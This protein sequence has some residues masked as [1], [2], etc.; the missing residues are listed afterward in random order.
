MLSDDARVSHV[1]RECAGIPVDVDDAELAAIAIAIHLEEALDL[2]VPSHL[3]D[4][5]HLARPD[6]L[7][8][9]VRR[10]VGGS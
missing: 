2:T 7:E 4:H 3:I 1:L 9:T 10:L 8:R 5:D 6:A